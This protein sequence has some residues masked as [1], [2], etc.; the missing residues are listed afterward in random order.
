MNKLGLGIILV[1]TSFV[2]FIGGVFTMSKHQK[3]K[4]E[5]EREDSL[6]LVKELR[7]IAEEAQKTKQIL[8]TENLSKTEELLS[9]TEALLKAEER[10]ELE[11]EQRVDDRLKFQKRIKSLE[12]IN[13]LFTK[14]H[15][16]KETKT[17]NTAQ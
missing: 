8:E 4:S 9:K 3:Q 5:P 15:K 12:E 1:C 6:C 14:A 2:G 11:K 17:D 7:R 13:E 10:L 16:N